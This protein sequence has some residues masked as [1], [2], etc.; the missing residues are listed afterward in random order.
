M[1][2]GKMHCFT[3][4]EISL[5]IFI[6]ECYSHAVTKLCERNS[7]WLRLSFY[8]L[9][10]WDLI[11][12]IR[13]V[14]GWGVGLNEFLSTASSFSSDDCPVAHWLKADFASEQNGAQKGD[15]EAAVDAEI[16]RVNKLP[17]HSSYAIHRMKVL[18]KLRHLLSIKR[19]TS[20]DEELELLFATLSIW[21]VFLISQYFNPTRW[22]HCARCSV[23]YTY[24]IFPII[25]ESKE[26]PLIPVTEVVGNLAWGCGVLCSSWPGRYGMVKLY[27]VQM[28]SCIQNGWL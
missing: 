12:H 1:M 25:F 4:G 14:F 18:N 26:I 2:N 5:L 17:A 21:S 27:N 6:I 8:V 7:W 11:L 15:R 3:P 19:T 16:A 28:L 24:S 13:R 23:V 9:W 20:Q 22:V 10:L